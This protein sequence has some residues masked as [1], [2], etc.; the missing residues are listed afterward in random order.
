MKLIVTGSR[1]WELAN[2]IWDWLNVFRHTS[3][4]QLEKLELAHGDCLTGADR[5]TDQWA[6][7]YLI[8]EPK[9]YPADWHRPCQKTCTHK[10][11]KPGE[12]CVGAGPARNIQMIDDNLDADYVLGFPLGK[13]KGTRGCMRYAKLQGLNVINL[14]EK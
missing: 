2:Y 5:L 1:D 11:R 7:L 4:L 10:P 12:K 13:S 3:Y 14:G 9:R 8:G 6:A